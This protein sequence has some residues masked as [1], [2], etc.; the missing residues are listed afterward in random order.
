MKE[1]VFP[2]VAAHD[3]AFIHFLKSAIKTNI[4]VSTKSIS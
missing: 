4:E 2:N 1:V 3:V